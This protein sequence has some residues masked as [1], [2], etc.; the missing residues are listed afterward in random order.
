MIFL[1]IL[2]LLIWF[3]G[4]QIGW[5]RAL[6]LGLLTGLYAGIMLMHLV[7][8]DGH[9]LRM[10]TGESIV[11]WATLL[12]LI[13]LVV[14]YRRGLGALKKRTRASEASQPHSSSDS[15]SSAELNRYARH[16]ILRE[17]G[18]AGQKQLK[19]A[20]VLVIGAG[21][22]GAPALQYLAAAGVGTLGVIDDDLSLIHI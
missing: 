11:P 15:F 2:A 12:V 14:V 1:G 6:R 21:G 22:L 7:L 17:I 20:K 13:A 19:N 10:A 18:G 3:G 5:P 16:I 8:P 4:R 9:A